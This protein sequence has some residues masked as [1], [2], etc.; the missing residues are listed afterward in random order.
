MDKENPLIPLNVV[1]AWVKAEMSSWVRDMKAFH[2][3][4]LDDS[5]GAAEECKKVLV[6]ERERGNPYEG[7][8]LREVVRE[9][10]RHRQEAMDL[11]VECAERYVSLK[12]RLKL[13][14]QVQ[15]N[16]APTVTVRH[17]DPSLI[18]NPSPASTYSAVPISM[19]ELSSHNHYHLSP[20][21][22]LRHRLPPKPT[23]S[24]ALQE[25]ISPNSMGS[26]DT[27]ELLQQP[28]VAQMLNLNDNG[29]SPSSGGTMTKRDV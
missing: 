29:T 10:E 8:C 17:L 4:L 24:Y 26:N 3:A 27:Q 28:W 5:E 23:V 19:H 21:S 11:M 12:S 20:P 7:S 14:S 16:P 2:L 6:E 13:R 9:A 25:P 22:S 15:Q 1:V 18:S